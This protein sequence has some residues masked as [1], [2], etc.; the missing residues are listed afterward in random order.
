M[1]RRKFIYATGSVIAV[2]SLFSAKELFTVDQDSPKRDLP[3]QYQQPVMKA[4]AYGLNA[5]NPHNTQAWKF[6][7]LSPTEMLFFVD[8]KRILSATD[9]T[10]RQIHIGCGCFLEC[11]KIGMTLDG[12]RTEFDFFPNG[13]NDYNKGVV[14]QVPIAKITYTKDKTTSAS[15]LAQY[16]FTRSTSRLK[17]SS[18]PIVIEDFESIEQLVQP[19][20]SELELVTDKQR[21]ET[22]LP[23]L[24][25][26]MSI[27]TY[28]FRTHEESRKWFREND[29]KIER[30]KDGINLA[31]NG[32]KGI[33]KWFAERQLKGLSVKKWH[34]K[35]MNKYSL[36]SHFDRVL[37]SPGII[38]LK[39]PNNKF[40]DWINAGIE[41]LRLQ[42]A[43]SKYGYYMHP[44]SQVLQEFDEMKSLRLQFEKE[45]NVQNE[46]KIQMIVRIG[47]SKQPYFSYRRRVVEVVVDKDAS[48]NS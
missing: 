27:E 44:L 6:Q 31:G 48:N 26:G 2:G 19:K 8:E 21:L 32:I 42:M 25:E 9:P 10:T 33:K 22:L 5:P 18:D 15:T 45:M 3:A 4:I 35:K 12:Y 41:Y 43:C 16:V 28:T 38:A 13:I 23:I 20:A 14:G 1:D 37:T 40:Q 39:T 34:S 46:E 24:A 29:D 30:E 17:Y 47:K 7:I 36:K 11:S